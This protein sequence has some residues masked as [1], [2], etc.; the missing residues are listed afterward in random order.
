MEEVSWWES[1][2]EHVY[3]LKCQ[4]RRAE[5]VKAF[6]KV[7]AWDFVGQLFRQARKANE[8]SRFVMTLL[9]VSATSLHR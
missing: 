9:L 4:N 3:Y 6:Y 7:I 2:W 1:T 5:Y 8:K